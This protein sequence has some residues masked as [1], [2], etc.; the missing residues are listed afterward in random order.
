MPTYGIIGPYVLLFWSSDRNERPH[1]HVKRE[2]LLAK[3]WVD[4]IE[5]AS[6]KGFK[7]H[8][9]NKI[10]RIVKEH[11]QD[12]LKTWHEYFDD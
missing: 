11:Q 7:P 9:L 5:L 1:I 4:D 10:E 3:F 6:N 2:R 12:I 8:E